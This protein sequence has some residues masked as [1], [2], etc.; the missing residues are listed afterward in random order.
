[1]HLLSII[2]VVVPVLGTNPSSHTCTLTNTRNLPPTHANN[3]VIG[4][5]KDTDDKQAESMPIN[6]LSSANEILKLLLTDASTVSAVQ[7]KRRKNI[8]RK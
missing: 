6:E 1:M 5:R 2:V 8:G 7:P 4:I 3:D